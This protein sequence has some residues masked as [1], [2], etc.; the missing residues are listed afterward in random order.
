MRFQRSLELL[1]L[2]HTFFINPRGSK[3]SHSDFTACMKLLLKAS[4]LIR[5][6]LAG[7]ELLTTVRN[8]M[9]S[10]TDHIFLLEVYSF[11]L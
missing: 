8:A 6:D 4:V 11:R 5:R 9:L 2:M 3:I 1:K 10:A 7:Y